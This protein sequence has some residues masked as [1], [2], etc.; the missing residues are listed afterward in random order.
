[1]MVVAFVKGTA[2]ITSP[3]RELHQ[4]WQLRAETS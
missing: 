4:F 2:N 3:D 1:M